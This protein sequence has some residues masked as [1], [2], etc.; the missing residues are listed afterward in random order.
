MKKL[1]LLILLSI[2]AANARLQAQLSPPPQ[3]DTLPGFV[4]KNAGNN[5]IIIGWINNY[6]VVKQISIQR[7]FDSLL[8]YKSILTVPD[9]MA[10]QNGYMDAKAINDHMFYRLYILLENGRYIFTAA[11]KPTLDTFQHKP[12][13]TKIGEQ[14]GFQGK[15]T[16]MLNGQLVTVKTDTVIS[17]GKPVIIRA[18]PVVINIGQIQWGDSIA[19]PNP[20]YN[21]PKTEV[22]KPSL[23]VFTNRDGYVR[24]NLP[25]EEKSK[26]YSIKFFEDD[27]TFLFELKEIK[28]HDFKLD[29]TNF[30]HAGW[31]RFELY[32]NGKLLEKYKFYLEKDF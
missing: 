9:P 26:K 12:L 4:V 3:N 18:Q 29:K 11:K 28:E 22:F 21:K 32:E 16:F 15:D 24:I 5:R 13:N 14:P 2:I 10:V 19:S 30:Y 27:N 25:E 8:N 31:F 23:R 20:R 1:T 7:S 6:P 17:N